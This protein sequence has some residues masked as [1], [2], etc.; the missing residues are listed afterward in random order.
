MNIEN[1]II[2]P[3]HTCTPPTPTPTHTYTKIKCV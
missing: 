3:E 2:E 1:K